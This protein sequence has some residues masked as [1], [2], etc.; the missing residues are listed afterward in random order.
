M[1]TIALIQARMGSTRLPGKTLKTVKGKTLIEI[2]LN[3]LE[4][5]KKIDK[6]I[7]ATSV[8]DNNN[9]LEQHVKDLGHYC[10]RGSEN[11]VLDR[12]Y[13]AIENEQCD[14]VVRLTADCPLIDPVLIDKV[15][16]YT[17][18]QDV[19]YGSNIG[20]GKEHFPD[21]QDTEVFKYRVLE[22]A[23]KTARLPSEREHVTPYIRTNL[24]VLFTTV[25]YEA[26][27]DLGHIRM[28]VDTQKDF[29]AIEVLV[30]DLGSDRTWL[31]YTNYIIK[32]PEKFTNQQI[33][34]NEGYQ[35][36]LLED[37]NYTK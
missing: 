25:D 31:D 7:V 27:N 9:E 17:I 8:D 32:F 14:Y 6:I 21:G 4:K 16:E 20:F 22:D 19:D 1:R 36:S 24:N 2:M 33:I 29:D 35:K 23:W 5:C 34:R 37:K 12:F 11:D 15:I 3:R 30:N 10:F 26:E 13:K 28:T 18:K